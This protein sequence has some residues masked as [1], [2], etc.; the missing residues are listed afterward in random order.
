MKETNYICNK[1]NKYFSSNN[2]L[3]EHN[4]K[5]HKNNNK[6]KCDYC[7]KEFSFRQGKHIHMKKCKLKYDEIQTKQYENENKNKI[8]QK[9]N[10]LENKI[11]DV[12]S[13]KD[14]I[15][16]NNT[17][18]KENELLKNSV[19]PVTNQLINVI[20]D[21]NKTIEK[22]EE[23]IKNNNHYVENDINNQIIEPGQLILND[24]V[25]ISRSEDGFVNATQ[26][27]QAG[28]KRFADWYRLDSTKKLIHVL[29]KCDMGI[30]IS[31]NSNHIES[32]E[33]NKF[34][35]I[36]KGNS[37]NF[38]QGTW[39]HPDLAIQLAQWISPNFALQV[40]KW[41]RELF[42]KGK[43]EIN[44]VLQKEIQLKDQR[45]K[46]LENTCIKKQRRTQY[47]EKNV[48]YIV[49]TEDNKNKRIYIIGKSVNLTDRLSTYNKTTEHEVIYYKA[50]KS[51]ED[52]NIIEN[53]ILH[54]LKDY[55][56]RTN[57]D[58]FILPVGEDISLFTNVIDK[59]I[60]F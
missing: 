44:T 13:K 21:K 57:R 38:E 47:T 8:L 11:K 16:E 34:I 24:I 14:I 39:I 32:N 27:C 4:K 28:G 54:K 22:Q 3:W 29:T 49:T 19:L 51:E 12:E 25:I 36:K 59:C 30:P 17:L 60:N 31:Q 20:V 53:M 46:L 35:D 7:N 55:Q 45:I 23:I 41:I 42:T 56:E 2:S 15:E 1:C 40:S 10:E 9:I 43:V 5:F 52:M 58:R 18:K 6:L 48:I 33:N 50:C 26:L 37:S